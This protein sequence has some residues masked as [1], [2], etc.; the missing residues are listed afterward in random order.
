[1]LVMSLASW[2]REK[3]KFCSFSLSG[4]DSTPQEK[5]GGGLLRPPGL[6]GTDPGSDHSQL[7]RFRVPVRGSNGGA[8][9]DHPRVSKITPDTFVIVSKLNNQ[10]GPE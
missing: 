8:S 2:C 10:Q 7:C 6:P 5:Q 4:A 1:M 9:A 3:N